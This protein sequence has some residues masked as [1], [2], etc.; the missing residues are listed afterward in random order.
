MCVG[1]EQYNI[2]EKVGEGAYGE[3]YRARTKSDDVPVALKRVKMESEGDWLPTTALREIAILKEL[4]HPNI[5][6][7][8]RSGLLSPANTEGWPIP[9]RN[10]FLVIM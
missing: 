4:H 5:V 1:N 2:D 9:I 8:L 3:V 7:Y 6:R 10:S